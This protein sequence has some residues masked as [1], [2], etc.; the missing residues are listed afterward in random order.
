VTVFVVV[1]A[2]VVVALAVRVALAIWSDRRDD[3]LSSAW[4]DEHAGR[5]DDDAA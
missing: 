4:R 2:V 3:P 5:P 1:L